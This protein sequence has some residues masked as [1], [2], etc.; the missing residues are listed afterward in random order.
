MLSLESKFDDPFPYFAPFH[1]TAVMHFQWKGPN[2]AVTR[3]VDRLW[4][5]RAQTTCLGSG[6]KHKVAKLTPNFAPKTQKWG[7]MH[8]QLEYAWLSVW[9]IISQQRCEIERWFQRTAYRKLHQESNGHVT[10][11]QIT[12]RNPKRSR[13]WPQYLWSLISQK[14]CEKVG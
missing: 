3:P 9:H 8:F 10:D 14:L 6:Y 4:R 2:T 5:L 12:S 7:S 1:F 13:S 11:D